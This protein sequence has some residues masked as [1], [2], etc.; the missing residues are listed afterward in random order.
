MLLGTGTVSLPIFA[1]S[2]SLTVL[3]LGSGLILFNRTEKTFV[4]II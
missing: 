4:D 3:L 2:A 1:A